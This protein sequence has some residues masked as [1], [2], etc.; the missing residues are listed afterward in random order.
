[1]FLRNPASGLP[2]KLSRYSSLTLG[3]CYGLTTNLVHFGTLRGMASSVQGQD[4]PSKEK[5]KNKR[6][7]H[8]VCLPLVTPESVP[9]LAESLTYFRNVTTAPAP[10][11]AREMLARRQGPEQPAEGDNDGHGGAGGKDSLDHLRI[12]PAQAHRPPGTFHLTLGTMDLSEQESM[13]EALKLLQSIDYAELLRLS[14]EE[15]RVANPPHGES[16]AETAKAVVGMPLESSQRSITLPAK[17]SSSS[18]SAANSATQ[19]QEDK[20]IEPIRVSLRALGAF[21]SPKNARVFYAR[22]YDET[23]RLYNFGL[24][25][26]EKF[27]E[28]GFITETR[29]LVLHATVANMSYASRN[30]GRGQVRRGGGSGW[31][32]RRGPDTVDASELVKVFDGMID[33]CTNGEAEGGDHG[34]VRE[35]YLW[36]KNVLIDRVRICKMGAEKAEDEVLGLEYRPVGEKMIFENM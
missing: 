26:R 16:N 12:I 27:R 5:K 30:G 2:S 36:A 23:G 33:E 29:P 35:G 10:V 13:D 28:A 32:K 25:V 24:A 22:P 8:F 1:M 34:K 15:R 18:P 31:G 14:V 20:P 7:T 4:R 9:Q 6:D 11:S 17:S 3:P 21:S 19:G